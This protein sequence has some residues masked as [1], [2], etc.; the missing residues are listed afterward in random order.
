M[1]DALSPILESYQLSHIEDGEVTPATALGQASNLLSG[2]LWLDWEQSTEQT[3][4]DSAQVDIFNQRIG[5]IQNPSYIFNPTTINESSVYETNAP[6]N[7]SQSDFTTAIEP[8]PLSNTQYSLSEVDDWLRE[9]GRLRR[10][11]KTQ[12]G[13][14]KITCPLPDCG[15]VLRRPYAL[16]DHLLSHFKIKPYECDACHRRFGTES[17]RR[18]HLQNGCTAA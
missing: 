15:R 2:P 6:T 1:A 13:L 10:T 4:V 17:N 12:G 16:K 5:P 11:S 14:G 18:R 3:V 7:S 9:Y 8:L